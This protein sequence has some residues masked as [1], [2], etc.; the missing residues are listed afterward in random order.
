MYGY[1]PKPSF[2]EF[3]QLVVS[4]AEN[5]LSQKYDYVWKKFMKSDDPE[6]KTLSFLIRRLVARKNTSLHFDITTKDFCKILEKNDVKF[7]L[8]GDKIRLYRKRKNFIG[9]EELTYTINFYGWT[10]PVKVKM[11][12][13]TLNA[14]KLQEEYP[15]FESLSSGY[16]NIYRTIC[17]FEMPLRR[18]KDE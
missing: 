15:D 5:S 8:D 13:D 16:G 6:I 9:Y 11:A 4:V 18:L 12:R 10:R 3:E 1:Y 7:E 2:K 17:D 14:L